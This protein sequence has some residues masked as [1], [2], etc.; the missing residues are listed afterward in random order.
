L[1]EFTGS[2]REL[3]NVLKDTHIFVYPSRSKREGFPAVITEAGAN[4]NLLI[5]SSFNGIEPVISNG[6]NGL[7]FEPDNAEQLA[8]LLVQTVNNFSE[9]SDMSLKFYT[10]VKELFSADLMIRKHTELYEKCLIQ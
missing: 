3:G 9:F 7:L 10:K 6:E 8:D 1:I 4:N 2:V 5:S